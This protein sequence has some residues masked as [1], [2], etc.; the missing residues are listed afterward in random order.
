M[1]LATN[2]YASPYYESIEFSLATGSTDYDLDANQATFLSVFGP[3]NVYDKHPTEI[4]IR[5]DQTI[6][7][8]F[9][10]TGN[11]A[12]TITPTDS[13]LSWR[14]EVRNI[15]ITNSSGSTAAIKIIALP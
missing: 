6:S 10:D 13:P 3:D 12:I 2:Q 8:K 15:Y 5:T 14:G 1:I 9:N 7:V 11:H 4:I